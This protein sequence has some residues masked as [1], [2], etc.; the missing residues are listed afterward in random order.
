MSLHVHVYYMH[1][2]MFIPH[3][4]VCRVLLAHSAT[5]CCCLSPLKST[6]A[7]AGCEDGSVVLWDLREPVSLHEP[8]N[9][10]TRFMGRFPTF[11]TGEGLVDVHHSS[12]VGGWM[13][14]IYN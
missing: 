3:V 1:A 10:E 13:N 7:F 11:C 6:L 14:I 9:P 4:C 8:L 12:M 5:I 2:Y